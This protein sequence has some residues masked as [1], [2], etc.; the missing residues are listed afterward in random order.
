MKL[1]YL[2]IVFKTVDFGEIISSKL[3]EHAIFGLVV[4]LRILKFVHCLSAVS[5][6]FRMVA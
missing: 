4:C 2:L 6:L 3:F 1:R 5:V